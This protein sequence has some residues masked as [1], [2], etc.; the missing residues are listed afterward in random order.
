M[1]QYS[2]RVERREF[3]LG[4]DNPLQTFF[5]QVWEDS[6]QDDPVLWAGTSPDEVASV[7]TLA[8]LM[9]PYG[10]IP[11]QVRTQL[12]DDCDGRIPPTEWQRRVLSMVG[13]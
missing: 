1:S 11:A 6:D 5:V 9:R 2:F 8:E 13:K 3:I 4:W 10:K 12:R 7:E